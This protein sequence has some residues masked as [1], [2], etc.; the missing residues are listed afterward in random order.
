M[1][2]QSSNRDRRLKYN[3]REGESMQKKDRKKVGVEHSFL[4]LSLS[5]SFSISFPS[6]DENTRT[7]SNNIGARV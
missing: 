4:L 1:S 5:R 6:P 7:A 3:I 2:A